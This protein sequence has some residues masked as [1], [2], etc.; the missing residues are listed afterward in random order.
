MNTLE[1]L[2]HAAIFFAVLYLIMVYLL[3]QSTTVA[4]DRSVLL[5]AI[6]L[7]YMVL[8]GHSFPPG[9]MNSNIF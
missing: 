2:L 3:K 7:I 8:F 1:H 5:A 4:L 9:K 6:A